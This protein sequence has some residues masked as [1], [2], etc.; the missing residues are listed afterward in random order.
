[1]EK[2][3]QLQRIT[4]FFNEVDQQELSST[5]FKE[6]PQSLFV[7]FSN[8]GM[9]HYCNVNKLRYLIDEGD[10]VSGGSINYQYSLEYGLSFLEKGSAS[11]KD[12]VLIQQAIQYY[13]N[14]EMLVEKSFERIVPFA[15]A[16]E[17]LKSSKTTPIPED[18]TFEDKAI[19]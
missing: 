4:F 5:E 3:T 17:I 2:R 14:D 7:D 10:I 1:M 8:L 16:I 13:S 15:K 9:M 18:Q 11:F 19:M 12:E 6:H